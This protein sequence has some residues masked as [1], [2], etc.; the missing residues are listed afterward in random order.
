MILYFEHEGSV[1]AKALHEGRNTVAAGNCEAVFFWRQ[2]EVTVRFPDSR[3]IAPVHLKS[4]SEIFFESAG[5]YLSLSAYSAGY[6]GFRKYRPAGDKVRIGTDVEDDIYM[7]NTAAGHIKL[8]IDPSVPSIACMAGHCAV[9]GKATGEQALQAGDCVITENLVLYYHPEFLMINQPD[10]VY[11]S[12]PVWEHGIPRALPVKENAELRPDYRQI[13][14][15]NTYRE[16]LLDPLPYNDRQKNPLIFSMGPA[17]TMASASLAAGM[18][19]FYN[20]MLNG[21]RVTELLPGIM[22]PAV[23]LVSALIWN[24]IQRLYEKHRAKSYDRHR[25]ASY[26][27]YLQKVKERIICFQQNYSASVNSSFYPPDVLQLYW[28]NGEKLWQKTPLHGDW[29]YIRLG[30]GTVTMPV[31]LTSRFHWQ[32]G[33]SL[34]TEI[35]ILQLRYGKAEQQPVLYRFLPGKSTAVLVRDKQCINVLA[36]LLLQVCSYHHPEYLKIVIFAPEGM[37][38]ENPWLMRI[39]HEIVL[40]PHRTRLVA[41]DLKELHQLL[42]LIEQSEDTQFLLFDLTGRLRLSA[43][44]RLHII[45]LTDASVPHDADSIIDFAGGRIIDKECIRE[46]L[47]DPLPET[48]L[49]I[50][51][52]GITGSMNR[53]H[54]DHLSNCSFFE[55]YGVSDAAG[56]KIREN[57]QMN[58]P[59]REL[60]VP[61]GMDSSGNRIMLDLHENG[62]G[63]HGLIA[64]TTGSGKS[65]LI[66]TL[67]LSL[68]VRYSPDEVQF[69]I[70]DFKGGGAASA[71]HNE[72]WKLPHLIGD[73]SNLEPEDMNRFLT[74]FRQECEARER[75]FRILAGKTGK[76]VM[77]LAGYRQAWKRQ[78]NLP[79]HAELIVIVD[80]FA[81][82][83]TQQPDFMKE[84]ISIARVGRSLGIHLILVTQKP[85]GVVD[86]QIRANCRF[87]ICLKVQERQDSMELLQDGCAA[88]IRRTGEFYM[89]SD[90]TMQHGMGGYVHADED[91]E[92]QYIEQLDKQL[93]VTAVWHGRE[94][95]TQTQLQA[96]MRE[97]MDQPETAVSR[98]PFCLPFPVCGTVTD[99]D[100][101]SGVLAVLDDYRNRQNLPF[102]AGQNAGITAVFCR[103]RDEKKRFLLSLLY[104]LLEEYEHIEIYIVDMLN[105]LPDELKSSVLI[106]DILREGEKEKIMNM[107]IHLREHGPK[108]CLILTDTGMTATDEDI[109]SGLQEL[110]S[111][112]RNNDLHI[113]LFGSAASS[114]SYRDLALADVRIALKNDNLQELTAVFEK[115]VRKPIRQERRMLIW[116]GRFYEGMWY[117]C[118]MADLN[119]LIDKEQ[120]AEKYII[121]YMPD[122]LPVCAHEESVI[123]LGKDK[124][125]YEWVMLPKDQNL[126]VLSTYGEEYGFLAERML[127]ERNL[128]DMEDIVSGTGKGVCFMTL[129]MYQQHKDRL[130]A[131][132]PVLYVG[133]GFHEQYQFRIRKSVTLG[134]KD[135][136][137]FE[138]HGNRVIRLAE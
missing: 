92:M 22:L 87:R 71:F 26:L 66:I 15:D 136:V 19:S 106:I 43:S 123:V 121:P 45:H 4:V 14:M 10:N 89:F 133:S 7:Q 13:N 30:L 31:Q 80:E 37:L 60:K 113:F 109:R 41:S 124:M 16:E 128:A 83:K 18:L 11:V 40:K 9:N 110:Y 54:L 112:V 69:A 93:N 61:I 62:Q 138:R 85:A 125:T 95:G 34:S 117:A 23:M 131:G 104:T 88:A 94:K 64:G 25:Q 130:P 47:P 49:Y 132:I 135:A 59:N 73:I 90:N 120:P 98:S 114:I 46:F 28:Q 115:P 103:D 76:P 78:E 42:A 12:L 119:V 36:Y 75:D 29:L 100:R 57:W 79:Y 107:L 126:L 3:E 50:L 38:W 96:V 27:H 55:L 105:I 53:N 134:E 82:L 56:L 5:I 68:A 101:P 127:K 116:N 1:T 67:I 70:I 84:L 77:N 2:D 86:E 137:L 33:D 99:K 102:Y 58:I 74:A 108:R 6:S 20:G 17:I 81:E 72:Q 35:E 24:P 118:T 122:I 32:S 52:T 129:D 39:P 8:V 21:R 44:E 65:E 91:I 97:I 111:R 63:P 48:D 51:F